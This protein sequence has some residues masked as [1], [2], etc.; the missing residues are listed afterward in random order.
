MQMRVQQ[1]EK[2]NIFRLI[3]SSFS[4]SAALRV[5]HALLSSFC[6]YYLYNISKDLLSKYRKLDVIGMAFAAQS[7][8]MLTV[9][10]TNPL[11]RLVY[12]KQANGEL[13]FTIERIKELFCWDGI[14][15][16]LAL[17]LNP[18]IHYAG[19]KSLE[20]SEVLNKH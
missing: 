7:A 4:S 14:T 8:A 2:L 16:A 10:I 15:P 11:D 13:D 6:Y 9:I 12:K 19:M 20:V 17:C 3:S 18:T 1:K 5:S